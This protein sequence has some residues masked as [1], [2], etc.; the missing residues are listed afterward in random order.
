MRPVNL[1]DRLNNAL[2]DPLH[3]VKLFIQNPTRLSGVDGLKIIA[4]PL[5]IHHDGKR[6]LRMT[7]LLRR[8]LMGTRHRQVPACPQPDIIGERLPCTVHKIRNAL[9]TGQLHAIADLLPI[10]IVCRLLFRCAAR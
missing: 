10:L 1:N 8:N 2:L 3:T 7:A 9:Q 4:L 5:H 6:P